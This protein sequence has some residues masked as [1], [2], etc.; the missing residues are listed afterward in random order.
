MTI[1][2]LVFLALIT[3]AAL[4]Q[5]ALALGAPWGEYALGGRFPGALPQKMRLAALAQM[6]VLCMFAVIALA[7]SGLVLQG[8]Y[9]VSRIAIW[10][11]AGFFALGSIANLATPS[12][13][14]RMVWA[15][16]NVALLIASVLIAVSP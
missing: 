6:A 10:L 15:P 8:A 1:P 12:R 16:V 5:L 9:D 14:E 4:F 13:R 7:R 3:I 11:V 2:L